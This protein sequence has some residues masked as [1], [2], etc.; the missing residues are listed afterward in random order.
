M[1]LRARGFATN[2]TPSAEQGATGNCSRWDL[3]SI[4]EF[5]TDA[6]ASD[7]S[8]LAGASVSLSV[9]VIAAVSKTMEGISKITYTYLGEPSTRLLDYAF[10]PDNY[11]VVIKPS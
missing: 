2:E 1:G 9:Q 10:T 5:G 6:S 11:I 3:G 4:A 7:C 8:N